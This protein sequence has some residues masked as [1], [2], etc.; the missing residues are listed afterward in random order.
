MDHMIVHCGMEGSRTRR[1][2]R[3]GAL[4]CLALAASIA[5]AGCSV[6]AEPVSITVQT[7]EAGLAVAPTMHGLFFE[8]INY[9][10]D[11]GLY[12][13]LVQNRSFEHREPLYAWSQTARR[14]AQGHLTVENE[15]PLNANN[16]NFLRIHVVSAG[17]EGF[18]AMNRGF[19]GI[20]VRE[21]ERYRFSVY[22]RRRAG[23]RAAV[24]VLLED[25]AGQVLAVT[26]VAD[27]P[28]AWTKFEAV[29][30]SGAT[31]TNARVAVLATAAGVVDLD[32]VSLFPEKTFKGRR[33]GLRPDL[34]RT[35]ADMK[36]GFLRF[37]GGCVV[38]GKDSANAYRWKDTI[39]DVAARKQNWNLWQ[40]RQ[41]PQ[42]S[43]TYGLGFFEYFQFCE[44]IGAEP[45]PVLNCGMTCQARQGK[46]VPLDELG[47]WVQDALDLIEFANGPAD[48]EWGGKRAAMGHPQP[49]NLKIL[50]VGNEQWEQGYFDRYD[51]FYRALKTKHPEIRLISSAGPFA[52]DPLW[53]FAWDKFRSGTPADVVDEHYYVPPRWLLENIDRYASYDRKGPKIFVGEFAGHDSNRRSNLRSALSEAAYM[54]GLLQNADVVEMASYAPLFAKMGHAQWRPNL[55]WFD[56]TRVLLTPNYHVQALF[57]QNRPDRVLPTKVEAPLDAPAPKGMIGVG[58]W[59]TQAEYKDIRVVAADGRKLFETDFSKGLDGWKTVGGEWKAVDGVLRQ[60]AGGENV[61]AVAGDPSWSDYTLTLRARKLGGE[62]GFLVMF[63]TPDVNFPTWWNLGGWRNTG[64]ALQGGLPEHRVPGSIEAGRWYDIRIELHAGSVKAYLDGQLVQQ[65][66]RKPVATL[67]A[68]AGLD[69]HAGEWV[70]DVVNPFAEARDVQVNFAGPGKVA[71]PARAT[72]LTSADPADENSFEQPARVAPH[73]VSL[74]ID[75]PSFRHTFPPNSLTVL[76]LTEESRRAESN[77]SGIAVAAKARQVDVHDPAMAKE[78]DTFY[79][80]SSGPGITFYSSKDMKAWRLRGRVFPGDPAWA[81]GVARRFNGHVWAPDVIRHDGKYY[82][83]YAVSASGDNSSAVGLTIN[84]TLD[85]SSTDYQW[86]DQGVVIQSVPGRDLW[87]AIDPNIIVDERGTPWMSFGSFWSGIKLVKL[88]ADW[89]VLAQP[90][91]WHCIAKRERSV[92]V[93]E[94]EPGPAEI[95]GPFIFQKGEYYYLFTSWGLCCRGV[96]STYRIVVGRSKDVRGPYFD[97]Q[98][99]SLALGGGSLVLG[100]TRDWAGRGGNSAYTF[101]G[102]DYLVFHAYEVAD[103]G[104]Q[105]LKIVEM[106][107]DDMQWPVIDEKDFDEYKSVLVQ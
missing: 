10:A 73:T 83:Y 55:V 63:E 48:S 62:E 5:A 41:S 98:G 85:P 47:P 91:E 88:G 61:R 12:A 53:H 72:I 78:D 99:V 16:R 86:K 80:F 8:D 100:P 29:L 87:N 60:S 56:N 50:A 102:K 81:R 101:D 7:G 21:G 14:G 69:Q 38:E 17:E 106:K 37:P 71:G 68:A 20:A 3:R 76:R 22:A 94:K 59:N 77:K 51:V 44:D 30:T 93:D 32:M 97:K 24:R 66:Q 11:G 46:P 9:G 57:A 70:L 42:Y 74:T 96:N 36:P 15:S 79:L 2:G 4:V 45:V 52:D 26:N 31:A 19:D 35:L 39:G 84:E 65:A 64:H 58:T 104:L 54:T 25:A 67:F 92:L 49:F 1:A 90:Q 28:D 34:A 95:E 27:L 82:L 43:Q 23:E 75:G 6:A 18:G 107:W 103:N 33:N 105:K 40:D 13:E 89:K